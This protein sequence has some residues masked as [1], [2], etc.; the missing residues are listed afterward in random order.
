MEES[1]YALRLMREDH[2]AEVVARCAWVLGRLRHRDAHADL[3]ANL[4]NP[5]L[6]V[7]K[8]SAWALGELG[9]E[10]ARSHLIQ[11]MDRE[12]NSEVRSSIG[13]ALKKLNFDST[14]IHKKEVLQ[15]LRSP[16]TKDK[17]ILHLVSRL[18]ELSWA[19]D[20]KEIVKL[21]SLMKDRNPSY[22]TAYMSWFQRRPELMA[23]L[24]DKRKVF[25]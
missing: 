20:D 1:G 22:F 10:S 23:M 8:W 7:R 9:L 15:A 11:A 24:D 14:R 21:R 12:G 17:E 6:A 5:V 4:T 18:G 25:G 19:V 13:G 2:N 16:E 3:V